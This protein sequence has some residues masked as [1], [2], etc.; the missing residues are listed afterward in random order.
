MTE[1]EPLWTIEETLEAL[2]D[3]V[4][5]C[6]EELR[7]ELEA[8]IA[9]YVAKEAAKV[10]RVAAVLTQLENVQ[11][12]AKAEIERLQARRRSA[13]NA[14]G[15]LEHYILRVLAERGGRLKGAN[16]TLS[17][18]RSEALVITDPSAIPDEWRRTTLVT[19]I[20]KDP[21]KRA[22]KAGQEIPGAQLVEHE[23]LV[24]R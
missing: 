19:D 24:R 16:V 15:R 9:E 11:A 14:A 23:H 2:L 4:D 20:P 13:E 5:T 8:K 21:I 6:P 3:S 22:L 1:L 10:D 17:I 7:P 18:R 12:N